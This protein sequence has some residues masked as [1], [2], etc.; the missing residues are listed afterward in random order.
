VPNTEG[1]QGLSGPGTGV[2]SIEGT[3][4]RFTE[5]GGVELFVSSEKARRYPNELHAFQDPGSGIWSIDRLEADSPG[6]LAKAAIEPLFESDDPETLHM[7]DPVLFEGPEGALGMVVCVHPYNGSSS[8]SALSF[9]YGGP[10]DA[11]TPLDYSRFP[12]GLTWDVA[13]SRISAIWPV[14]TAGAD[15][16]DESGAGS[17]AGSPSRDRLPRLVFY[18]GG[19]CMRRIPADPNGVGWQTYY[20]DEDSARGASAAEA[21]ESR[22]VST[23]DGEV[24]ASVA[25]ERYR[26]GGPRGYSCEEFAGAAWAGDASCSEIR[27]LSRVRPL[28]ASA[29]GTGAFRYIDVAATSHGVFVTWEQCMEDGSHPLVMNVV[30]Y[31]EIDALLGG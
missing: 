8:H 16:G 22:A 30:S 24:P 19:E 17:R 5:T 9:R 29:A 26:P 1:P 31:E 25:E 27:R 20:G 12:R 21:Q 15:A 28:F 4:L 13:I 3:K 14:P 10:G 18:D 6:G 2:I 11:F 7:K 23:A